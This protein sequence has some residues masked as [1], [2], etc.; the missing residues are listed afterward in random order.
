M[1]DSV[2]DRADAEIRGPMVD[3]GFIAIQILVRLRN[4]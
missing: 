4:R 1:A 2:R 3:F